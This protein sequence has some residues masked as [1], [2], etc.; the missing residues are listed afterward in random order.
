MSKSIGRSSMTMNSM[1]S[2]D[3]DHKEAQ[4]C[5]D[6]VLIKPEKR[7]LVENLSSLSK[8]WIE[9][10]KQVNSQSVISKK[11]LI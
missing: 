8:D 11:E 7:M 3:D 5:N 6:F 10:L 4:F 1:H 9:A 2:C